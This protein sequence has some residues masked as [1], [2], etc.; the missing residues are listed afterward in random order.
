MQ[1]PPNPKIAVLGCGANGASISADLISQGHDVT[2]I[3]QWPEHVEA[4]RANGIRINMPER[5]L[6]VPAH[7]YNLCEV[8]TFKGQFDIVL[9]VMKAYDTAW[10]CQLIE[11]YLKPDGL[12][13][14]VQNGMTTDLAAAIVGP[15]RTMGC[16]IEIS[17]MMMEPGIVERHSGPERCYF[18]VGSID[19]ATAGREEEVA[20]LL[21]PSGRVDVVAE[22]RAAKWMK[23][24]SNCTTLGLSAELGLP[25]VAA[26]AK[27]EM[28]ELMLRSGREAL[29]T[30]AAIGYPVLPIFGWE[31]EDVA[32]DGDLV[33][34]LLDTLT[35]GF[36]LPHTTSTIFH[37]WEKGR[38]SEVG[39]INGCV[40]AEQERLG[41]SAPV[42]AA[43]TEVA[44][45]I[46]RGEIERRPENLELLLELAAAGDPA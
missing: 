35:G 7:P 4:M 9:N 15:E 18:A 27:P 8:A 43:A 5:T 22:I 44:R 41:G 45:R 19:R 23:L 32:E 16:V 25:I 10:S 1:K 39:D 42:N 20:A 46:E 33:E 6:E 24:V 40:V 26:A 34:R 21:R 14:P 30:G 29:E 2:M 28:R 38:H 31:Q 36:V 11:P 3:E 17:S 12:L 13:V 37:D